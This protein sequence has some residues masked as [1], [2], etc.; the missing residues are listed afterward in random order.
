MHVMMNPRETKVTNFH[1]LSSNS[2]RIN[3]HCRSMPKHKHSSSDMSTHRHLG[4][5]GKAKPDP[6]GDKDLLSYGTSAFLN[7]EGWQVRRID[8]YP[9]FPQIL[10]VAQSS[11]QGSIHAVGC[12]LEGSQRQLQYSSL[13]IGTSPRLLWNRWENNIYSGKNSSCLGMRGAD[14]ESKLTDSRADHSHEPASPVWLLECDRYPDNLA[15]L[16]F[17]PKLTS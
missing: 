14:G 7:D 9:S 2:M 13:V 5:E 8:F 10:Q 12:L 3:T 11:A 17:V 1:H 16:L 4:V 15:S 6:S